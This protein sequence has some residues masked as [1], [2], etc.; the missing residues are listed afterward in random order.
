MLSE[1]LPLACLA[2]A[3]SEFA[4]RKRHA[5]SSGNRFANRVSD[6]EDDAEMLMLMLAE[7]RWKE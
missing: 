1:N 2:D 7:D 4:V 5:H 6:H 3:A